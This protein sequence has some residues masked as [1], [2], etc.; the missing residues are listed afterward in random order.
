MLSEQKQDTKKL[1]LC[2][3]YNNLKLYIHVDKNY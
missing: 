3:D 2:N 1:N